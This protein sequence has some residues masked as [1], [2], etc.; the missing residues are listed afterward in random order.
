MWF[1]CAITN[2]SCSWE[3]CDVLWVYPRLM[4]HVT[5]ADTAQKVKRR[6]TPIATSYGSIEAK[7]FHRAIGSK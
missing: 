3:I 5:E 2:F 1:L 4:L 6:I 7:K